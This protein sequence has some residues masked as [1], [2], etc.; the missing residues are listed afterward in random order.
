VRNIISPGKKNRQQSG[1]FRIGLSTFARLPFFHRLGVGIKKGK[2]KI[3]MIHFHAAKS[4]SGA[5]GAKA[6]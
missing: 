5:I 6:K 4:N 2:I 1:G 3:E